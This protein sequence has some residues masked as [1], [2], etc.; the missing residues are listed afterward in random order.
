MSLPTG[1]TLLTG[2]PR[3][4]TTLCCK[5]LNEV[6]DVAALVEP[7]EVQSMGDSRARMI[8]ATFAAF[9]SAWHA[10]RE[11]SIETKT[12]NEA[13]ASN[14]VAPRSH[15]GVR[16]V[17]ATRQRLD[18]VPLSAHGT[19][20]VKHNAFFSALLPEIA[21]AMPLFAIIRNPVAVLASWQSV[22]LPVRD[23][24]IPAGERVD[25][26]LKSRLDACADRMA[27]QLIVLDWFFERFRDHLAAD[28]L[29]RYEEVV[30]ATSP[31]FRL[32]RGAPWTA[33]ENENRR[34]DAGLRRDLANVL[35]GAGGS[36]QAFYSTDEIKA[37][38]AP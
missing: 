37:A 23:G 38:A 22:D 25:R 35:I 32:L 34:A 5:L 3:S 2:I 15:G 18:V 28:R 36:F 17:V 33:L 21:T 9:E 16:P 10:A 6:D 20:V 4:G 14:I 11:G 30:M 1:K 26:A 24:R 29:I 19:L 13:I 7:W 8:S 12:N 27:R 31:A